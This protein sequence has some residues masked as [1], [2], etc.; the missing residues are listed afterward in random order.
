MKDAFAKAG[1]KAVVT[2][3]PGIFHVAFGLE[4]PAR[5]FRDLARMNRPA[6]VAFT[7]ALLHRG[8]RAL[9]RGAWFMSVEHD[10]AVVDDTLAAV[11]D[12]ARELKASGVL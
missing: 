4:E 11:A 7:T 12:A 1:V 10:G 6:Y 2:G 5:D 8:V 3:F 9:E